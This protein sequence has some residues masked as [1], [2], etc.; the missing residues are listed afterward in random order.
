MRRILYFILTMT[1][2]LAACQSAPTEFPALDNTP[3]IEWEEALDWLYAGQ[4]TRVIQTHSLDVYLTLEDGR[5]L[6]T[7]E[8]YIDAIF[9]EIAACGAPCS[10][11][12]IATE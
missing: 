7:V 4:V 12:V 8:P 6:R 10:D 3:L 1:I 2:L 9:E 5:N 11:I